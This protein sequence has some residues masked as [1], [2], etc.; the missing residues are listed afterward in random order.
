MESSN[1][2]LDGRAGDDGLVKQTPKFTTDIK[3]DNLDYYKS[4]SI[5][6]SHAKSS[7][8]LT[9][10]PSKAL[11]PGGLKSLHDDM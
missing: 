4:K 7:G 9:Y 3:N 10:D 5:S 1:L 6:S 8:K 2:N 11:T